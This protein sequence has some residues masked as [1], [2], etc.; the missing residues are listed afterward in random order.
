MEVHIVTF[1]ETEVVCT[2]HLGSPDAEH[3]TV[4]K[5]VAWKLQHRLVDSSK[6]RHYGLH[7]IT[8]ISN[9][10]AIHRVDFCLSFDGEVTDNPHGI[11]KRT[12]PSMKC[13]FARDVGSRLNNTA[14]VYLFERWLP[15]SGMMPSGYP[16]IFHYVN[17]GPDVRDEEAITDVYLPLD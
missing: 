5:L 8:P 15:A 2:S 17:I 10:P 7:Y 14:A 16:V 11:A 4:R 1:P 13:A 9:V 6:Y 3:E 12:I